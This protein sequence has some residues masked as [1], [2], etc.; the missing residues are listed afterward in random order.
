M[1]S[2]ISRLLVM[3]V[4]NAAL[5]VRLFKARELGKPPATIPMENKTGYS[6]ARHTVTECETFGTYAR[7]LAREWRDWRTTE[8]QERTEAQSVRRHL[9]LYFPR[10]AADRYN[11]SVLQER[12]LGRSLDHK[13]VVGQSTYCV[14]CSWKLRIVINGKTVTKRKGEKQLQ[15][16]CMCPQDVCKDF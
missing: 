16:L 5:C 6:T 13:P 12:R 7:L 4:N 3:Q 9:T 2:I 1:T 10:G 8:Q 14:L 15:G 11:H